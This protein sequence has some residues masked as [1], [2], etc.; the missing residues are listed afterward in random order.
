MYYW[1]GYWTNFHFMFYYC[2][3]SETEDDLF[4]YTTPDSHL[5]SFRPCMR[6]LISPIRN[7]WILIQLNLRH[8]FPLKGLDSFSVGTRLL[9][10]NSAWVW[11]SLPV[12][13][14]GDPQLPLPSADYSAR[15]RQTL[16]PWTLIYH[17]LTLAGGSD[18]LPF[19]W[20]CMA[21]KPV[22]RYWSR[23]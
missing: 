14:N 11:V 7:L 10:I 21:R 6:I 23:F 20:V 12:K 3:T 22:L 19:N 8:H 18:Q 9:G 5:V 16:S 4:P 1:V 13:P 15:V 17:S 2:N